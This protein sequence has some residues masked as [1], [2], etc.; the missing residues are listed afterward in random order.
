MDL[1][2]EKLTINE[3]KCIFC[4]KYHKKKIKKN[5]CIFCDEYHKKICINQSQI[6]NWSDSQY[7]QYMKKYES[8][9]FFDNIDTTI[10]T[11]IDTIDSDPNN[12]TIL[13]FIININKYK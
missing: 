10:D 6:N 2:I 5:K 3:N 4:D 9:S 13:N 12:I 11:T 7:K 8:I 1:I